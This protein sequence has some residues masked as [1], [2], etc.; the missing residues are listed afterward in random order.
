MVG[1]AVTGSNY[2]GSL[3]GY[4]SAGT[5]S[6]CYATGTVTAD[7]YVGGLVGKNDARHVVELPRNR[8]DHR[9]LLRRWHWSDTATA[10][11]RTATPPARSRGMRTLAAW[12]DTTLAT[13]PR[14]RTA[15]PQAHG[16]GSG[17]RV[18]DLVGINSD[19]ATVSNCY[20]TGTVTGHGYYGRWPGRSQQ[21]TAPR[22]RTATPPARSRGTH[23]SWRPE[24]DTTS[25]ARCR[26]RTGTCRPPGRALRPVA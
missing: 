8:H 21:L 2:V 23:S 6:T 24:S 1:G 16:H 15:T 7:Y 14:C 5:V 18:G 9:R 10:Q 19:F 13:A 3:V 22:C 25:P 11:F 26:T 20:A 4:N 17:N 12:S